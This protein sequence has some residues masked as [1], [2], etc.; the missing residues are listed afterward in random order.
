MTR[1][2]YKLVYF[3]TE[4][5]EEY[6]RYNDFIIKFES[7][8][9]DEAMKTAKKLLT[10]IVKAKARNDPPVSLDGIG[11]PLPKVDSDFPISA[12]ESLYCVDEDWCGDDMTYEESK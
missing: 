8:N 3:T 11:D 12:I 7:S 2:L 1:K 10:D 6:N 4:Y 5:L 9:E